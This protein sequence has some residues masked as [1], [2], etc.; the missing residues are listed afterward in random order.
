[1][2]SEYLQ[3]ISNY[4]NTKTVNIMNTALKINNYKKAKISIMKPLPERHYHN[5][6]QTPE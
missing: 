4:N 5:N 2:Q 6:A 1:M 3:A